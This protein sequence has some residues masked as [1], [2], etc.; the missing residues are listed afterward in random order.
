MKNNI[1]DEINRADF[2]LW[3][4]MAQQKQ[5][6]RFKLLYSTSSPGNFLLNSVFSE[7]ALHN[8]SPQEAVE[9]NSV[10]RSLGSSGFIRDFA[11]QYSGLGKTTLPYLWIEPGFRPI[12]TQTFSISEY[13]INQLTEFGIQVRDCF[14]YSADFPEAFSKRMEKAASSI[15]SKFFKFSSQS[16][17]VGVL[18]LF[19]TGC[20]WWSLMNFGI[21]PKFRGK[22][23]SR[24]ALN[25]LLSNWKDNIYLATENEVLIKSTLPSLGFRIAGTLRAVPLNSVCEA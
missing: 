17:T 20:G 19:D 21:H 8:P 22:G 5:S 7:V 18:S 9:L 12:L 4:V 16:E 10:Y 1:L 23:F 25:S 24:I 6:N 13:G 11:N 14:N 2:R 3:S 15:G